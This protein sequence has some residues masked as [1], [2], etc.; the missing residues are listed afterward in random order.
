MP[1]EVVRVALEG[2]A[3][4]RAVLQ[5]AAAVAAITVAVVPRRRAERPAAAEP[6]RGPFPPPPSFY[7]RR[8]EGPTV[9]VQHRHGSVAV[10]PTS[11]DLDD[12]LDALEQAMPTRH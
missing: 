11:P 1:A 9:I 7:E 6:P 10:D 2:I 5:A 12:S 3:D 4:L 8:R